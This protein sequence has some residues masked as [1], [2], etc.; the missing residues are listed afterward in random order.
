MKKGIM[1]FGPAGSGKTTLGRMVAQQLGFLFIDID[2]HIWQKDTEIPSSVMYS[3]SEKISKLMDAVS[4][5]D[6]FVMEVLWIVFM[7][8]LISSLLLLYI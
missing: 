2:D 5:T 4:P 7:S 1:I 6:H 3:R 8:I